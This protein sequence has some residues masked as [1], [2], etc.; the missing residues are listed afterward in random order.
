[1]KSRFRFHLKQGTQENTSSLFVVTERSCSGLSLF[2]TISL[3][4]T[5]RDPNVGV[6]DKAQ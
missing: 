4:I 2:I 1:M 6:L 3:V 5:C